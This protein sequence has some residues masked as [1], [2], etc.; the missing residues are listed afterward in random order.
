MNGSGNFFFDHLANNMV[1]NNFLVMLRAM[2]Q[3]VRADFV[4]QAGCTGGV[5]EDFADSG[6]GEDFLAGSCIIQMPANIV[7]GLG[8]VILVETAADVETLPDGGID[9]AFE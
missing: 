4:D 6:V 8:S 5:T 2:N 7:I 3:A 9:L 1:V